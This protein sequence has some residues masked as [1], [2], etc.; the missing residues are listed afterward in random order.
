MGEHSPVSQQIRNPELEIRTW[1]SQNQVWGNRRIRGIREEGNRLASKFRVF[2]VFR[3][4]KKLKRFC[5]D[6]RRTRR[7]KFNMRKETIRDLHRFGMAT[8]R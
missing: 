2:R 3:G 4:S 6:V 5:N 7:N 8:T 1:P